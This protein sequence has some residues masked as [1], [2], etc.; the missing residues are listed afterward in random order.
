MCSTGT[1]SSTILVVVLLI[2]V[3]LVVVLAN[4]QPGAVVENPQPLQL[5][6]RK[7]PEESELLPV[8]QHSFAFTK[9]GKTRSKRA[10]NR[11]RRNRQ[12]FKKDC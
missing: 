10:G 11:K 5:P 3:V 2:V 9:S 7:T 12:V 8:N 6:R 1:T 4:N